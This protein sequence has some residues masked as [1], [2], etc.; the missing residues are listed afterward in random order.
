M[1]VKLISPQLQAYYEQ[2]RHPMPDF[3]NDLN[4]RNIHDIAN[5]RFN[6]RLWQRVKELND[7][8]REMGIH[9]FR[10]IAAKV[11]E[12]VDIELYECEDP[13]RLSI[14]EIAHRILDSQVALS[15][16]NLGDRPRSND[17]LKELNDGDQTSTETPTSGTLVA[18][19][20]ISTRGL[21][22]TETKW[23][24][25]CFRQQQPDLTGGGHTLVIGDTIDVDSMEGVDQWLP[26][27]IKSQIIRYAQNH[28]SQQGVELTIP[29]RFR[30]K[31]FLS[32]IF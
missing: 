21:S 7:E 14:S 25:D 29:W 20:S 17:N 8:N 3:L 15:P 9:E 26:R 18:T 19:V 1:A 2:L 10:R 30:I 6:E 11:R 27:R 4:M 23:L 24:E 31:T 5:I 13:S 32:R 16:I 12:S 28:A 22:K